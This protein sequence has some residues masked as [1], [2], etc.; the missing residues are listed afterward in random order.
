VKDAPLPAP[1]DHGAPATPPRDAARS[2]TPLIVAGIVAELLAVTPLLPVAA[3]IATV[4]LVR[5]KHV[6]PGG[7]RTLGRALCGIA[8]GLCAVLLPL[9]LM[10]LDEAGVF[11]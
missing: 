1:P 2:A 3:V 9:Y 5:S 11:R 7:K 8:L 4:A 6:I 10:F